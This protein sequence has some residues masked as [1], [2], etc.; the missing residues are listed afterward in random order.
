[1]NGKLAPCC[2][3]DAITFLACFHIFNIVSLS[4]TKKDTRIRPSYHVERLLYVIFLNS[5]VFYTHWSSIHMFLCVN[6]QQHFW[7]QSRRSSQLAA[8]TR[9]QHNRFHKLII[10]VSSSD[11]SW[12][13]FHSVSHLWAQNDSL[14][15]NQFNVSKMKLGVGDMFHISQYRYFLTYR[16]AGLSSPSGIMCCACVLLTA[17]LLNKQSSS[18]VDL[19]DCES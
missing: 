6:E 2:F 13:S 10:H 3:I 15:I 5:C 16:R 12:S 17:G 1:M 7:S 9:L 18:R 14:I 19:A 4:N 11:S 8:A